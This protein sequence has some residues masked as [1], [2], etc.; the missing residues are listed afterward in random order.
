MSVT[1]EEE[2]YY[3]L[4]NILLSSCQHLRR[5]AKLRWTRELGSD[6]RED[7]NQMVILVDNLGSQVFTKCKHLKNSILESH[8]TD[9]WD[10][11]VLTLVFL[12]LGNTENYKSENQAVQQLKEIR[13]ELAHH[14][15]KRITKTD[16]YMYLAKI[17]V[18][19][20]S[21]NLTE[22]CFELMVEKTGTTSALKALS[23]AKQC[24]AEAE[25]FIK[26]GDSDSALK[27]Y[28]DAINTPSLLP[29]NLATAYE[30]R[31]EFYIRLANP[32]LQIHAEQAFLDASK[33]IELNETW[34]SHYICAKYYQTKNAPAKALSHFQRSI[35]ISPGQNQVIQEYETLKQRFVSQTGY[36]HL[37][38]EMW[39][40]SLEEQLKRLENF[41]DWKWTKQ[42]FLYAQEEENSIAPGQNHV[43]LGN[44]YNNG[45]EV[46]LDQAKAVMEYAKAAELGNAQGMFCLANSYFQGIGV[47]Q[48]VAKGFDIYMKVAQMKKTTPGS[49]N[50]LQC[51]F[52]VAGAQNAVGVCYNTGVHVKQNHSV[53]AEWFTKAME[54][55]CCQAAQSLG[56]LYYQGLGIASD[57]RM[58]E[59][60]WKF[61]LQLGDICAPAGLLRVYLENLEPEL[62]MTC[63]RIG[64]EVGNHAMLAAPDDQMSKAV[65]E[66]KNRVKEVSPEI[67]NFEKRY[68][69]DTKGLLFGERRKRFLECYSSNMKAVMKQ[70]R[71]ASE[72][73]V[74]NDRNW[75]GKIQNWDPQTISDVFRRA[76][77][78]SVTARRLAATFYLQK[79]ALKRLSAITDSSGEQEVI[80]MLDWLYNACILDRHIIFDVENNAKLTAILTKYFNQ[81]CNTTSELDMKIRFCYVVIVLIETLDTFDMYSIELLKEGIKRYPENVAYY[82]TLCW[83]LGN[84]REYKQCKT[85]TEMGLQKFPNHP[86]ILF[87]KATSIRVGQPLKLIAEP[88]YELIDA[89]KEFIKYA[90]VDDRKLPEAYY[91][92]SEALILTPEQDNLRNSIRY[93][94]EKGKAAE[95]LQL[96]CYQ[97]YAE[98]SSKLYTEIFLKGKISF[99]QELDMKV[100]QPESVL[101]RKSYLKSPVR[102]AVVTLFRKSYSNT[103]EAKNAKEASVPG[104]R[105]R[106]GASNTK[107]PKLVHTMPRKMSCLKQITLRE[108]NPRADHIFEN[109][110]LELTIIDE[111]IT[112]FI[113]LHF[114]AE[115]YN[116]DTIR[117][118]IYNLTRSKKNLENLQVGSQVAIL[119]PYM[120]IAG[121]FT[122]G[123]RVDNPHCVIYLAKS[124]NVC[125]FCGEENATHKCSKCKRLYCGRQCQILDWKIMKH[126]LICSRI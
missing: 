60:C 2:N 58:A 114:I 120:R 82:V 73:F 94:Y 106:V 102:K 111:M 14:S 92:L 42:E 88:N 4:D 47:K 75:G 70:V 66:I 20:I 118:C 100:Q 91:N 29:T 13:N 67:E 48:D 115:D 104:I 3:K 103:M 10:M 12:N 26:A 32:D 19:L 15:T 96:P 64:R 93:Y 53:A 83:W 107:T 8:S 54:N 65:S 49:K 27:C 105:I 62:A 119:N 95:N 71:Y 46:P 87:I 121:D 18:A 21:L 22:K 31:S 30:N 34:K 41:D 11:S 1:S 69:L 89:L 43:F 59:A 56:N 126:K 78:G 24:W 72:P 28:T 122:N 86:E 124:E 90:A 68:N 85:Y 77:E 16:Y 61:A 55:G 84:K 76:I 112:Y 7:N 101:E 117:F 50:Q 52:G 113:G 39:P 17:K 51:N 123:I 97:P 5:I 108:M 98:I 37:N 40:S 80:S 6:W 125:R 109:H 36:H 25:K 23:L 57:S 44:C 74:R 110:V 35:S 116:G 81:K 99:N 38:P 79:E 63:F 45:W 9:E 33:A